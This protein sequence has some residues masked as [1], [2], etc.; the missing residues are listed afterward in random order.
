MD[1]LVVVSLGVLILVFAPIL[2]ALYMER[3]KR[4]ELLRLPYFWRNLILIIVMLIIGFI[5][6]LAVSDEMTANLITLFVGLPMSVVGYRWALQRL[7]NI[8][9]SKNLVWIAL[10]PIANVIFSLFLLFKP[11]QNQ[12]QILKDDNDIVSE[13]T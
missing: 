2:I 9:W 10:I 11:G 12:D 13:A 8:G 3:E 4:E 1:Y 6:G 7:R 5:C